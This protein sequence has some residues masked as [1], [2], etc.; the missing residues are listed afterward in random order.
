[1]GGEERVRGAASPCR[2]REEGQGGNCRG[3]WAEDSAGVYAS[4]CGTTRR[5]SMFLEER[6]QRRIF[7]RHCQRGG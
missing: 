1:M 7:H 3:R 5:I 6:Q 2:G 4:L